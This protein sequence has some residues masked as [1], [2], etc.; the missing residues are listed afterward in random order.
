[1][2]DAQDDGGVAEADGFA[3]LTVARRDG[4]PRSEG[5]VGGAEGL[6]QLTVAGRDGTG[7]RTVAQVQGSH[8]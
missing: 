8:N 3:Q 1:M 6:A 5:G 7:D 4:R 2:E